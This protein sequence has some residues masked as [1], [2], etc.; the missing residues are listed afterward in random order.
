M[1][2]RFKWEISIFGIGETKIGMEKLFYKN[3]R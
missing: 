1:I 3:Y 2:A